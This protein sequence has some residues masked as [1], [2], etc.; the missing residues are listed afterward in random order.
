MRRKL[1]R[2][3]RRQK[4]ELSLTDLENIETRARS[5]YRELAEAWHF[6]YVIPNHDGEDSDNWDAFYY[7]IGDARKA[8]DAVAALLE[9][10]ESPPPVERWGE[11]LLPA[12]LT[13]HEDESSAILKRRGS[14][15]PSEH[16]GDAW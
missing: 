6:Q 2:R 5:A 14:R 8:L 3:T 16:R 11:D 7:P 15:R 13:E 10:V 12:E 1:L 4:G 9:G